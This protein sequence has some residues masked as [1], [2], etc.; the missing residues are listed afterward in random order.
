MKHSPT[1]AGADLD[2]K[3]VVNIKRDDKAEASSSSDNARITNTADLTATV[4]SSSEQKVE[5]QKFSTA[6]VVANEV[7]APIGGWGIQ[8]V[9]AHYGPKINVWGIEGSRFVPTGM[10]LSTFGK[11]TLGTVP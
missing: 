8:R 3:T 7:V 4:P 11:F 10:N 1:A 5:D 6:E 9:A 2:K